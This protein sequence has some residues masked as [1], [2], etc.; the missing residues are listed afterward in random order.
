MFF[1]F[2]ASRFGGF[3]ASRRAIR[4]ITCFA[5][6]ASGSATIPLAEKIAEKRD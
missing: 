1:V 3:A 5:S 2:W 6:L 4:S